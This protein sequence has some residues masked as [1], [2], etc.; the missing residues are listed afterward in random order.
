MN[1]I[2]LYIASAFIGFT[3]GVLATNIALKE[4]I[5]FPNEITVVIK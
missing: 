2:R 5:T 4:L 1:D 3:F